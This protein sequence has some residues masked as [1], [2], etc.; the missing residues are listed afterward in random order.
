MGGRKGKM[1]RKAE[2]PLQMQEKCVLTLC[3]I[4]A[5][6]NEWGSTGEK[7]LQL[8]CNSVNSKSLF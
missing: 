1:Q 4:V 2:A 8:R 6:Q 3:Q 5:A 7:I